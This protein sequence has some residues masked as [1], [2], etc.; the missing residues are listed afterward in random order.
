[1]EHRKFQRRLDELLTELT[2]AQAQKVIA[3]LQQ[4]GDGGEAQ[5]LLDQRLE[6]DPKCAH[7]GSR[8]IEGWGRE[9]NGLKRCHCLDCRRTFN[10]LTGTPLAGLRKKE[11]WLSFAETLNESLS[12]R[13]AA[14]A[15]KVNKNTAFKWRH[16]FLKAQNHSRNQLFT[17]IAEIDEIFLLESFKGQRKLPRAARK[18]GGVAKKAGL[19]AEQIPILIARDRAGSHIDAVLP[20]RSEAAV[21][22]VLQGKLSEDSTLACIDGDKAVIAFLKAEGIEYE[23]IIASKG[24]HVH[25]KVLHIQNVNAYGGRF[26]QWLDRFNGVATKYLQSY[27]GWRRWL[28]KGEDSMTPKNLL[29]AAL[30]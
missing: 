5:R 1:M 20:D 25:E 6:D 26:K 3:A 28:E 19:S 24:E 13:K 12:V 4:R 2:Y 9:R 23:L 10:A 18:R 17:G 11:R 30:C 7:C 29:A 21:R 14:R 15:C 22:P 27:L 8:R 16:R